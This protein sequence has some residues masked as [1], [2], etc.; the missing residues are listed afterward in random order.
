MCCD[1]KINFSDSVLLSCCCA[2]ENIPRVPS[3]STGNCKIT[4][5]T[6]RGVWQ[7]EAKGETEV[8]YMRKENNKD[9]NK[10]VKEELQRC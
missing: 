2:S 5:G 10:R 8:L 9:K 7:R 3:Q 6:F 4:G 1:A